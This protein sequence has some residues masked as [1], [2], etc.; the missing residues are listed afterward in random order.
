MGMKRETLLEEMRY[1]SNPN[2]MSSAISYAREFL[3]DHPDDQR[4]WS[5]Y[6]DL[7]ESE[8]GYWG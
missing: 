8:R 3:R 7:M 6:Q 4:V 2:Q 1:A 5:A